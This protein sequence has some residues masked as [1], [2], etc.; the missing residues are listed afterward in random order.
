[1]EHDRLARHRRRHTGARDR[2]L[3]LDALG[4]PRSP[5]S[6]RRRCWWGCVPCCSTRAR[7]TRR[8]RSGS[9][10]TTGSTCATGSGRCRKTTR[11]STS[12]CPCATWPRASPCCTAGTCGPSAPAASDPRPPRSSAGT[13]RDLYVPAGDV[14]FWQAA[15]RDADD[16]LYGPLRAAI[17][18]STAD[19]RGPSLRRPRGRAAHHHAFLPR[20]PRAGDRRGTWLWL[21]AVVRHWNLDRDDPR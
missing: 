20:P 15:I 9:S 21:C 18:G 4:E 13:D 10:T 7:R 17:A 14:S 11:G 3:R 16:P 8:R 5:R 19:Q 1:M 6:R 12:R 2:H